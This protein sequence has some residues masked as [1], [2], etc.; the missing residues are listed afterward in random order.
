MLP[1]SKYIEHRLVMEILSQQQI[2]RVSSAVEGLNPSQ[3]AWVTGYLTSLSIHA[4]NNLITPEVGSF[5]Q[6]SSLEQKALGKVT[7]LYGSQ[8]GNS[9][10]IAQELHN[11]LLAD[12]IHS[13][14]NNLLDYRPAQLKKEEK[15]IFVISTQGNGEP[16]DEALGFFKFIERDRAPKLD[17]IEF[18]VLGLGD[19]SY[20]EFCETGVALDKRL[21][22]LGAERFL[23]RID[24]D[25]DFEEAAA[26]WQKDVI[27]YL[28]ADVNNDASQVSNS[29]L[30]KEPS[31]ELS[32][33]LSK[34]AKWSE[35]NP[36]QSEILGIVN[37]SAEGSDQEVYHLELAIDDYGLNNEYQPGDILALL[38]KNQ[39][40]LVNSVLAE[41]KLDGSENVTIKGQ[42]FSLSDALLSKLEI[43]KITSKV[44]K[45]YAESIASQELHEV[46]SDKNLLREFTK[47]KD[48]L[49]LLQ[50]YPES[51]EAQQLVDSL[52][53]LISRQYSIAS[54]AQVH[55]D[56]VHIL[57]KPVTYEY[58]D[59]EHL[60]VASNWLKHQHVGDTIPLYIKSNPG[61]KLPQNPED[62]IIMIG[63]GTGVAPYRSFLFERESLIAD[64][65]SSQGKSWLFF[66]E[67]R[68][69]SDFLYQTEWQKFLKD[70][71]LEKINVAFSRD[72][73]EKIYVQHKLLEEAETLYQWLQ[74]G[75]TLYVCGDIDRMAADVHQALIQIVS[76]QANKSLEEAENWLDEL[77]ASKRYQRDVY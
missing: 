32:Q 22:D 28:E 39:V 60:G 31:T 76:E 53:P 63:A 21:E 10:R 27:N 62:K 2:Q 67:Q 9:Q 15:V 3:L 40:E 71:T 50:A 12:G 13:S 35:T 70:K 48:L 73:K 38:P 42:S 66:G 5:L 46:A 45:N 17:H 75:A 8:T 55:T 65:K 25:I 30:S 18:A 16:P 69:Q 57:I 7:I 33:Q 72:Q 34:Q 68:F 4:G 23:D 29:V 24:A 52:R 51:I 26:V 44:V 37:L 54:S 49:D 58:Q 61:F 56:E 43:S 47:G 6:S 36:Y 77:K 64:G 20:D 19:S 1:T 74:E 59:R 11:A 14:F 41:A